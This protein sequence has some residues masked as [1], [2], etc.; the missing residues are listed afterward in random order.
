MKKA[1][2][3]FIRSVI[4]LLLC[5]SMLVGTT[6]AWFSETI[7]NN[8]NRIMAGN[9]D[10]AM[11]W[12]DDL[13]GGTWI[14]ASDASKGSVFDYDNWE[15]GYTEVRYIKIVNEG[16]LA[17]KYQL[18][19]LADGVVGPLAD[20]IDVYFVQDA[21]ENIKDR[22]ELATLTS[23]GTLVKVLENKIASTGGI[24]PTGET[25]TGF[26]SGEVIV[27]IAM[28]MQET[29]GNEY[30]GRSIGNGFSIELIATQTSNE[31]DSFGKDYDE[32]VEFPT[33][34]LPQEVSVPVTP[35][36]N[37]NVPNEI[38]MT[39]STGD[40]TAIVPAGTK[41]ADGAGGLKL[42]ITNMDTTNSNITVTE[43]EIVR[44]VDVHIEGVHADNTTPIKVIM[45][46]MMPI[47]L[48][49]G[50]YTLH[51]V[52]NGTPVT[53]TMVAEGATPTHD[54]F[55]YDPA[56]GDVVL[57]M[58]S[59]SEVAMVADTV[60][61]WGGNRDYSWYTNAVAPAAE[62]DEPD[63]VIANADQLA[64][65]GAIVGGMAK[66]E[67][68]NFLITYT[69]SDGDEHHNDFF[70]GK[71]VKLLADINLGDKESENN[72]DLIFYP[73]G[74]WNSEG[75]YEKTGTRHFLRLLRI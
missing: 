41:M 53:M 57:Y 12:T 9:L 63:Y 11:Y 66:D 36:S 17:L 70:E 30:Q 23:A 42:T 27:A 38:I 34:K 21:K 22:T 19:L 44:S 58:K 60:N 8:N 29:A 32:K 6:Y 46:A 50:N 75:T 73:I 7:T 28:K 4:A 3:A 64:A 33:V 2:N 43:D 35:D 47:G 20:V 13:T 14:D 68:G 18:S 74:Y 37:G 62:S 24:L 25:K 51:H 1:R 52:Q 56:T 69:D 39:T 65:F 5:V 67:D 61:A 54:Q 16:S 15:P 45:K 48:N 40:I 10:V 72:P 31:S 26:Y 59:F 55:T 49:S 71:T